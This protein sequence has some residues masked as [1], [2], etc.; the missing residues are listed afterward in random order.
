MSLII[1]EI[2]M[3]DWLSNETTQEFLSDV[4]LMKD[5]AIANICLLPADDVIGITRLQ[6]R[7]SMCNYI[8]SWYSTKMKEEPE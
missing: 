1:T 6:E 5:K 3:N 8:L 4:E 2:N 7:I